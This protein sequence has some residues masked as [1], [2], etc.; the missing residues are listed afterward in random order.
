MKRLILILV[1]LV[2]VPPFLLVQ[3]DTAEEKGLAIAVEADLRDMEFGDSSS[4]L[5]MILRNRR[6]DESR[7]QLRSKVLE[8]QGDGDKSLVVFDTPPDVKGTAMLT[9]SYK[10]GNDDRWLCLPALKRVTRI[11]TSN[12]SG[13]FM[14]SEFAYE[15]LA[16]EEV[17]KFAYKWLRD[18]QCPTEGYRSLACFV[19]ERYPVDRNSGY[20]RQVA[21]IEQKD[22]RT[23]KI[24]YY[25]RKNALL[26]SLSLM[27]YNQY[28]KR[29]WR[30]DE[31]F[32]INHQTGKSTRLVWENYEFRSGLDESDFTRSSLRRVR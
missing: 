18:E 26:K 14:G 24:D 13:S 27:K 2:L 5:L 11:S 4:E 8:V 6:G 17:K 23:L 9:F 22:Y 31:M 21:W 7:R 30:P 19:I 20:T 32:M 25:D 29:Y 10:T 3:A 12:K 16:S 28:L 15:D 1:L